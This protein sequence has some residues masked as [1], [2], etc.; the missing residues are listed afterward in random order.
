MTGDINIG[1]FLA[2]RVRGGNME[3]AADGD[4]NSEGGNSES[5]SPQMRSSQS[6]RL[7]SGIALFAE[8]AASSE[9][10]GVPSATTAS[11]A[12]LLPPL[13]RLESARRS[14]GSTTLTPPPLT[15]LGT[16]RKGLSLSSMQ[17]REQDPTP[18]VSPAPAALIASALS[19]MRGVVT[20][21]GSVHRSSS[22][23]GASP[24]VN[25]GFSSSNVTMTRRRLHHAYFQ[26]QVSGAG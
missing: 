25:I 18:G 1:L 19:A 7:G 8:P 12:L 10:A 20:K 16:A 6:K 23:Q 2:P 26:L 13:T 22:K 15:R 11:L 5:D 17:Q 9:P 14:L 21:L 3:E 4:G 24:I